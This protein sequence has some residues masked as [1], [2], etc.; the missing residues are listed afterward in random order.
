MIDHES[1]LT[2]QRQ[3]DEGHH[4][5][6]EAGERC[7]QL[8][9]AGAWRLPTRV[10]LLTILSEDAEPAVLGDNAGWYWSATRSENAADAAWAVGIA[11]YTNAHAVD[12]EGLVRCVR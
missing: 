9:P 1:G 5:W 8:S 12:T 3:I 11:R 10:E 7:A 2:W 4:T 6:I